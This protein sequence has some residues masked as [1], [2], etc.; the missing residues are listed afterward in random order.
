MNGAEYLC[1]HLWYFCGHIAPSSYQ[2]LYAEFGCNGVQMSG[3]NGSSIGSGYHNTLEIVNNGCS[4]SALG[5]RIAA[6]VCDSLILGG[7]NDWFL[8]SQ[9]E[10][11]LMHSNIGQGNNLGL[12]NIGGFNSDIDFSMLELFFFEISKSLFNLKFIIEM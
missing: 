8:P 2:A 7:Y 12:G 1:S 4:P 10:L 5:N 9:E 6:E 11:Y 3:A